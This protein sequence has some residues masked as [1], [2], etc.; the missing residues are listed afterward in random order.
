M[1]KD[2]QWYKLEIFTKAV[3]FQAPW[4]PTSFTDNIEFLRNFLRTKGP[5]GQSPRQIFDFNF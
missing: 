4:A 5:R 2:L 1:P 3:V